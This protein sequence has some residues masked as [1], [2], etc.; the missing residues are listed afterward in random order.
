M[1]IMAHLDTVAQEGE[2]PSTR[3]RPVVVRDGNAY[4]ALYG[5]D[6][7]EGISGFGNTPEEALIAFD[8][9]WLESR[10][11]IQEPTQ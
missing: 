2:R 3:L 8:K 9:A 5:A 7:Q 4:C 6:L 1:A 11:D 10:A